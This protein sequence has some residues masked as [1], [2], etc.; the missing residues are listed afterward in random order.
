MRKANRVLLGI[1][2]SGIGWVASLIG[3]ELG[4]AA[5]KLAVAEWIKGAPVK[6][7]E[8]KGKNVYVVEFWATWCPPCRQSIPHLTEM[9]KKYADKG[10][11]FVGVTQEDPETVRAFVEKMGAQMDYAVA[12][13][14]DNQTTRDYMSAFEVRKIPHA[15]IVDKEGKIAWHGHPMSGLEEAIEAALH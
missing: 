10:V 11:V 6:L 2:M 7:A 15:F 9:Q 4:S 12:I 1:A 5:P 14:Q 3:G 13:D 8:G